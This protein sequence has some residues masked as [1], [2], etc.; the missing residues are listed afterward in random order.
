MFL[1]PVNACKAS[2]SRKSALPGHD[3]GDVEIC[4]SRK[5]ENHFVV[6]SVILSLHSSFFKA[7]LGSRWA[8][9]NHGSADKGT[10]K[11]KYQLQFDGENED[12]GDHL[13]LLNR[14]VSQACL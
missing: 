10:I 5:P 9:G 7:S 8:S 2:S 4:L 12:S 6:R 14:A 1:V 13:D 11:W 3:D